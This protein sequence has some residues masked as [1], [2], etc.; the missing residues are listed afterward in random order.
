MR[1][2]AN[3]G[4]TLF[5]WA[6]VAG[7]VFY[8]GHRADMHRAETAVRSL[9]V[10]VEDSVR[11]E[12]LVTGELVRNWI[13]RGKIATVGE[14]LD[15]VDLA[16]IE[17]VVRQKGFVD[18]VN[19]YVS[20]DGVLRVEVSQRRP[21]LRLRVDGYDSYVTADGFVFP[22]PTLTAVYVP[23]VTGRY[24][25]PVPAQHVGYAGGYLPSVFV[26]SEAR[27]L[28]RQHEKVP[29]FEKEKEIADSVRAVRRMLIKKGIFES[30]DNFDERVARLRA[31]K[32][33]LRRKYHYEERENERRI[34]AVTARQEAEREN[35]KKLHK[36]YEDFLKLINFVK[37][38][39]EDSFWS[40]EIV[41]I[42]AVTISNGDLEVE[43]VPRTGDHTVLFG[44][45]ED[46]E[47]KFDRLLA[48][49]ENGLGNIGRE[50]YRTI[51]VKY[52]GQ[53]VC[54][55]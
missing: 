26:H 55:K 10:V 5:L 14:P 34:D 9:E 49:Y 47:E 2:F 20:Y 28:E 19:A 32:A 36:R 16:G 18:R 51:P 48:F 43:L 15:R 52:K 6:F 46:V 33:D 37:Y 23:V 21:A 50:H 40:A 45:I 41:Q 42:V 31:H 4:L 22:A 25:A 35:Q 54:R 38:I 44:A 8:F 30:H 27:V 3:I 7:F 17:R 11:N 53:V 39:E 29:F 13:A 24:V 12:S 1:R